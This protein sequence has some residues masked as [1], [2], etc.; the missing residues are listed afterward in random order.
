MA[1]TDTAP[2]A[3]LPRAPG[4]SRSALP[5]TGA[6]AVQRRRSPLS[7]VHAEADW[8]TLPT[9]RP[10]PIA[11]TASATFQATVNH[12]NHRPRRC[13]FCARERGVSQALDS[14]Q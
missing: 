11:T 14:T 9:A 12:S 4:R 8:A 3:R 7:R 13:S 6:R 10:T 2:C 5:G 1:P